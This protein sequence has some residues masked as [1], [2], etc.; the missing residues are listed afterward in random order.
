MTENITKRRPTMKN[1]F[2]Y[3][4]GD[5]Y[6]GG[7]F[8]IIGALFLAFLTDVVQMSGVAAGAIILVGKVWDAISDP[9]MGYISDNTRSKYGR[10]RIYFL[11]GIFPIFLSWILLWTNFGISSGVGQFIYYLLIY[12]LFN[13]VF[14]L[15]MVPYNTMP[16]EMTSDYNGRTKLMTIRMMFSQIGM[17]LGA[18]IPTMVIESAASAT[19]GHLIMATIF[20]VIF[21]VPWIFVFKGTYET[22]QFKGEKVKLPAKAVVKK[23]TKDFASTTRNK[24]LRIQTAMYLAAYV[25]MDIFMA[26]LVYY[27]R[28]YITMQNG[29]GY[30]GTYTILLGAVVI[31]QMLSLLIAMKLVNKLGNAKTYRIH[32]AVWM[33]AVLGLFLITPNLPLPVLIAV[34]MVTGFGLSGCVMTPYN[35]LAFVVDADEMITTKRREGTYAGMMT[36]VRKIAQALAIFLVG[37]FID[38]IGYQKPLIVGDETTHLMQTAQTLNGIKWMLFIAP[39]ILLAIGIISSFRF[40]ITPKNHTI[41]LNEIERLR[42]DESKDDVNP[43]TKAVVESITGLDYSELWVSEG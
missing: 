43:E 30:G 1:I 36:F 40:K 35:M 20:S 5:L 11:I 16:A 6:G 23:I 32:A 10:R 42:H 12:I 29:W 15:V 13:T 24:S 17:L 41:L 31:T 28:Y 14:T 39:M 7:A 4:V 3:A 9:T 34:C 8:F 2:S 33:V 25:S 18:L 38:L 37:V 27:I 19:T 21:S 26:L 22:Y